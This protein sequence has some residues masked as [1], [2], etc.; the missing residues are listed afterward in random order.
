[1]EI[2]ATSAVNEIYETNPLIASIEANTGNSV[3]KLF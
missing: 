2:T 3:E 1:M